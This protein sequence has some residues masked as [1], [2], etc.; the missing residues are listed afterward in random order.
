MA[1]RSWLRDQLG[2]A[3]VLMGRGLRRSTGAAG[4]GGAC[5]SCMR[6]GDRGGS[7]GLLTGTYGQGQA[8]LLPGRTAKCVQATCLPD[9]AWG[10]R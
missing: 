2:A 10:L 5:S 7:G 4:Q 3:V 6:Q 9:I 8:G 1:R